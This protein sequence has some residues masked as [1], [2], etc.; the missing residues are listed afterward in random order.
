[1]AVDVPSALP[2]LKTL[3]NAKAVERRLAGAFL[4]IGTTVPFHFESG[5]FP[6]YEKGFEKLFS[7]KRLDP[8]RYKFKPVRWGV[9]S[10][11]GERAGIL[12]EKVPNDSPF[13]ITFS[14]CRKELFLREADI[15]RPDRWDT[16]LNNL[17]SF[18][19]P[20]LSSATFVLAKVVKNLQARAARRKEKIIEGELERWVEN[21]YL[22][23]LEQP[24]RPEQAAGANPAWT[25]DK[26][27]V[28]LFQNEK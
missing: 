17:D 14:N 28:E 5:A 11:N 1:M 15:S 4:S 2:E 7:A 6:D 24:K 3:R 18:P 16:S 22:E 21:S 13:R 26:K 8:S 9:L 27:V 19:K 23:N 20:G 10:V 12:I 25:A